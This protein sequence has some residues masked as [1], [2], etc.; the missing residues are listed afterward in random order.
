MATFN[1]KLKSLIG[2]VLHN[3]Q[4]YSEEA[5]F[6]T[7]LSRYLDQVKPVLLRYQLQHSTLQ[8]GHDLVMRFQ[9]EIAILSVITELASALL[10]RKNRDNLMWPL[11]QEDSFYNWYRLPCTYMEQIRILA[12]SVTLQDD[13]PSIFSQVSDEILSTL[14][15]RHIGEFYTPMSIVRHLVEVAEFH[16]KDLFEGKKLVDPACGGGIILSSIAQQSLKYAQENNIPSNVTIDLLSRNIFG[17]DIQPFAVTLTRT[18][19]I[20]VGS[21]TL[22]IQTENR[23]LFTNIML[24]DPLRDWID[25]WEDKDQKFQFII[26]NP[27]YMSVKKSNIEY[28]QSYKEILYGHPNLYQLFLWWAVKSSAQNG[29]ISFLIP[30]SI[31]VGNFFQNLRRALHEKTHLLS[32]TRMIDRKGIVGEADH[33][34]MVLCLRVEPDPTLKQ[35]VDIRVTRNGR[36]FSEV[37]LYQVKQPRVVRKISDSTV[38][39]IV[40]NNV[41]DY[42]ITERVEARCKTIAEIA[43]ISIGNGGY[44]WNEHKELLHS[45]MEPSDLPLI[46]SAS[47]IPFGLE[48]PYSGSHPSRNRQ[49]TATNHDVVE[50]IHKGTAI[51]LQRITPRKVGR[52]L[53]A[54]HTPDQFLQKHPQYF[55][56]NHV[57]YVKCFPGPVIDLY[58][59]LGWLNSDILNFIFQLRNGTSHISIFE[60]SLLPIPSDDTLAQLSKSVRTF[61]RATSNQQHK[62][63]L[64]EINEFI[65][66]LFDLGPRHRQRITEVLSRKERE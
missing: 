31:L 57:N 63:C 22:D 4:E 20:L 50:K 15:D 35:L 56:E 17:F 48:F 46:S 33:Q 47:V 25:C 52:R 54:G 21:S 60:L 44:V 49:Y 43:E 41:L 13:L 66:D 10:D 27:P 62:N 34:M 16:P 9:V 61:L 19:L 24:I 64:K 5:D 51:L 18:Q 2:E 38:I 14:C 39:W 12:I 8:Q 53:V 29:V 11:F 45:K 42:T 3:I 37:D 1:E 26:G 55:L 7:A 6:R 65:F 32:V 28:I 58:G 36:S 40:S 23:P 30:Q 59:I